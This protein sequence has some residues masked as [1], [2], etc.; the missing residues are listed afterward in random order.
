MKKYQ[1]TW[2]KLL[3]IMQDL[4]YHSGS[5]LGDK[6]DI[7]RSAVWK[8]VNAM[9]LQGIKIEKNKQ[10]GYR[11]SE[12]LVLLNKE[13]IEKKLK[14]LNLPLELHILNEINSTNSYIKQLN[15]SSNITCA[16]SEMQT[17]GRGRFG[18]SWIS[19]YA[20][21]LYFSCGWQFGCD[22]SLL[23]G[24]SQ[25]CSLAILKALKS[26]GISQD[27]DL[28]WPNDILYKGEKLC[29][30]LI[31]VL[32][33]TNGQSQVII[34][35]GMNVNMQELSTNLNRSWTSLSL[36]TECYHDRNDIVPHIIQQLAHHI[37][38]FKS[39]GLRAFIDDWSNYDYLYDKNI[40]IN[41]SNGSVEGQAKGI[42]ELG[43]LIVK[44][45]DEQ[46]QYYSSGDAS[47]S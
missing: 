11:L 43:R 47:L 18:R 44:T 28:K 37:S 27:L 22:L 33:E 6:L 40:K 31:E 46:L 3:N 23:S 5:E 14:A 1:P 21:N 4:E 30:I 34:G 26:Y 29:G 19:P 7:T 36:I 2:I 9:I 15:P 24:L 12:P 35:I 20:K 42:D 25:V 41:L 45:Q 38:E 39:K 16:L 32:A 10:L 17:A 8:K 13:V